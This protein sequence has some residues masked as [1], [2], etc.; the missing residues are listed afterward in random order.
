MDN[1]AFFVTAIE[2]FIPDSD[3]ARVTVIRSGMS[4]NRKNW[5]ENALK[6][7]AEAGKFNGIKMFRDHNLKNPHDRKIAELVSVLE[8]TA[9]DAATKRV[10][11]E[12]RFI[13]KSF[14]AFAQEA[15]DHIGLSGVIDFRGQRKRDSAGPF[16]D[17]DDIVN[18]VSVDWVAFPA[19]GGGIDSFISAQ[20]SEMG[21]WTNLTA[22]DI[23][24][25]QKERP[26]LFPTARGGTAAEAAVSFDPEALKKDLTD[27]V[28]SVIGD[29]VRQAQESWEN[30]QAKKASTKR[31]TESYLEGVALPRLT[32]TRIAAQFDGAAEYDEDKLKEA[33]T[34]AE[35]EIKEWS[36][37]KGG[38]SHS[39]T[40]MSGSTG[41]GTAAEGTNRESVMRESAHGNVLT[42]FGVKP[43]Q[44]GGDQK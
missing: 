28:K 33:V 35:A 11:G 36:G 9:W 40:G 32:K 14:Q 39:T 24:E 37:G 6:R 7:A 29:A 41:G 26:E 44:K 3:R 21:E 15:K 2:E 38:P 13:D 1:R 27:S 25:M 30:E 4:K 31:A 16:W 8:N 17:V 34:A 12:A 19:A 43:I 42:A 5:N 18:T 10:V 22:D 23:A 20:E